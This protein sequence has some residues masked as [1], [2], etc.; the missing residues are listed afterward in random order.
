MG[1]YQQSCPC[2]GRAAAARLDLK[3]G[4]EDVQSSAQRAEA[5]RRQAAHS[6]FTHNNYRRRESLDAA[7][8]EELREQRAAE[9]AER[10]QARLDAINAP[11][12]CMSCGGRGTIT[13][14]GSAQTG[15]TGRDGGAYA[16][17]PGAVEVSG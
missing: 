14:N 17:R 8:D 16:L 11:R 13:G 6:R 7:H 4:L 15:G 10:A 12:G 2:R 5:W 1:A 3:S 9:R